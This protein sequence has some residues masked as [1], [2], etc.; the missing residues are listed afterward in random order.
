MNIFLIPLMAIFFAAAMKLPG[1]TQVITSMTVTE[2]NAAGK[3]RLLTKPTVFTKSGQTAVSRRNELPDDWE[4]PKSPDWEWSLTPTVLED[5]RVK[6]RLVITE[7]RK[8]DSTEVLIDSTFTTRMMQPVTIRVGNC[9]V[10]INML[11]HTS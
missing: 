2:Y 1:E 7:H 9:E 8:P 11:N 10:A 3:P 6:I 4:G 5:G